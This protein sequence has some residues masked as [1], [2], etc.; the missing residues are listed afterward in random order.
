M[1][2]PIGYLQQHMLDFCKRYPG[3]HYIASDAATVKVARSLENRGLLHITDCGMADARGRS[4]LMVSY[5]EQQIFYASFSFSKDAPSTQK[6]L[7]CYVKAKGPE[8]VYKK[9]NN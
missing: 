1:N 4:V 6:L 5:V 2:R 7:T 9:R 8:A 3:H